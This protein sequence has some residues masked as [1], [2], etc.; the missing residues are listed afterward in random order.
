MGTLSHG[1]NG[2]AI[3]TRRPLMIDTPGAPSRPHLRRRN[4]ALQHIFPALFV[5]W[6]VKLEPVGEI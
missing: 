3:P 1:D 2:R 6:G 5:R 4:C